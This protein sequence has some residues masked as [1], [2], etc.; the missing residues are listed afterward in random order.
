MGL[1][2]RMGKNLLFLVV[3]LILMYVLLMVFGEYT[4]NRRIRMLAIFIAGLMCLLIIFAKWLKSDK[5]VRG[6]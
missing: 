2:D 3:G 6:K 4:S 1:E 5:K